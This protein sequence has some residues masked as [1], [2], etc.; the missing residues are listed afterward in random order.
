[1]LHAVSGNIGVPIGVATLLLGNNHPTTVWIG[2]DAGNVFIANVNST[3]RI[4]GNLTANGIISATGNINSTGVIT[5]NVLHAVSGNIGVPFGVATLNLGN[6]FP[7][8]INFGGNASN[9]FM[10]NVNSTTHVAGNLTAGG[11]VSVTGN[12]TANN[13]IGSS[14]GNTTL[15]S[16]TNLDLSANT[17]VRVT[18]GATFRLPSLNAAQIANIVAVNGDLIYNTTVNKIQGYEAGA[19]GNLI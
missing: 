8:T 15:S 11:A 3:T 12:V 14:A 10:A 17:A 6:N 2:G 4:S 1:V 18:G 9:I 7:T 16:A 13:F 5:G 19:W